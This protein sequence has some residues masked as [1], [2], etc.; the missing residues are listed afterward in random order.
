MSAINFVVRDSAGNVQHGNVAGEGAPASIIATVDEDISLNLARAQVVSYA[1]QGQA[2]LV[3][4]IDGRVIMIE[5]FFTPDGI[6]ENDLYLSSGGV[7]AQVDLTAA[8]NGVYYASYNEAEAFGKWSPNDDLF[9]LEGSDIQLAGYSEV[10]EAAPADD[11]VG[12]LAA[13]LLSGIGAVGASGAGLG[14]AALLG[15]TLL[16]DGGGSSGVMVEATT[17]AAEEGVV[18]DTTDMSDGVEIGGTGTVGGTVTVTVDGNT[19]TTTVDENGNWTVTFEPGVLD[20]GEYT[21]DATVTITDGTN[22]ETT[23]VT[24]T[25]DTVASVTLDETTGG[26]GVV[27]AVELDGGVTL[28]GTVEA[29]STVMVTVGGMAYEATVDGETWTLSLPDGAIATGEYDLTVNVE[30]T[31]AY[32]NVAETS[33]IVVID[34]EHSLTM[35]TSTIGGNGTVNA[36]EY[37]AGFDVTGTAPAGASVDVTIGLVTHTVTADANGNWSATFASSDIESGTYEADVTAV[38]VDAAGNV[39]TS[40]GTVMIDTEMNLSIDTANV[41]TDGIVNGAEA[42]DGLT[43]NGT[44]EAG[45]SVDVTLNGYTRT[46]TADGNGNWSASWTAGELPSGELDATVTAISTDG[47]GNTETTS[48]TVAIDTYVNTLTHTS[49]QIGGDGYVNVQEQAQAISASGMVEP[50]STVSVS[51][52]GVTMAAT[53]TASGEWSVTYPAGSLPTGEYTSQLVITA[54]DAA[55]NTSAITETVHVDTVVGDVALSSDPIE[56]DDVVN[57]VEVADGVVISG[58]ATPGL[59]VTVTLGAASHQVIAGA[60]GSWSSTFLTSEVPAGTYEAD[61]TASITDSAGNSKTV[62]DTV[63]IDTHVDNYAFSGVQIEGDGIVNGAEAADGF[64]VSGT[65]EPGSTV[66]VTF[67]GVS[68]TVTAGNDGNWTVNY[69]SSEVRGGEYDATVTA[70]ATDPAGNVST[71]TDMVHVDT[72]VNKLTGDPV[73]SDNVI[74]GNEL[75]DG[76]TLTGQVE[77]GSTVIVTFD[78]IARVATVD[79][80]GNWT[81]DYGA[82]EIASGEYTADVSIKA[83]DM[84]GNTRTEVSTVDIDTLGPDA[85]VV[86]SLDQGRDGLRSIG[87]ADEDTSLQVFEVDTDGSV[88]N[89]TVE[90]V[91][92]SRYNEVDLYFDQAVPDGS[93]LVLASTDAAGNETSTLFV[94][95]EA[96]TNIVNIDNTGLDGFDIRSIDLQF[97]ENSELELSAQ[98]ITDLTGGLGELTILGGADDT[99]TISGAQ[100]TGTT[101]DVDGATYNIYTLG[102]DGTILINEDISVVI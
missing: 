54:T 30:A 69:N 37:Q 72:I 13:P 3:T 65:V 29:G 18:V 80:N 55:G 48:G 99:V 66:V 71:I 7:L 76:I 77:P 22:T 15:T 63:Q 84:Y 50:G 24:L 11:G 51:L 52:A 70:R 20:G 68:K 73:E 9:F 43:L 86:T 2:L 94:L 78:G 49:G 44:S 88:S 82:D 19:E 96:G 90:A 21:T 101:R 85:P 93:Q 1:R 31:D 57:A 39:A 91:Q 36:S 59:A 10:Y 28:T 26:D 4:L 27:N 12:M 47:A 75:A 64:A 53:V 23:T 97:A 17:G 6:P 40:T 60:D 46:V 87:I 56:I 34:T 89:L 67:G 41:E 79:A 32:G 83:T 38:S 98:D 95:D 16:A 81:V 58:T 14:A 74:N 61:I 8:E 5:G 62:S 42:A 33:G 35:A 102:D 100:D 25:F 92:D 45:A